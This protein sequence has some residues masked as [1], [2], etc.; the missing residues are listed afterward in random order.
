MF[1]QVNLFS[2]LLCIVNSSSF[3]SPYHQIVSFHLRQIKGPKCV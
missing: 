1:H 3:C 2:S